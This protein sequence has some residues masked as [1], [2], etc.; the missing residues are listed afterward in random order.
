MIPA[1]LR[2]AGLI[3]AGATFAVLGF[4]Y[5]WSGRPAAV[6]LCLVLTGVCWEA[7]AYVRGAAE[8]LQDLH[9]KARRQAL[10]LKGAAF[11][12]RWGSWCCESGIVSR[13]AVH[14]PTACTGGRS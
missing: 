9:H 13:G 11:A 8:Q 4:L 1:R 7:S 10:A 2:Y 3:L 14:H 12:E 5:A 6:L